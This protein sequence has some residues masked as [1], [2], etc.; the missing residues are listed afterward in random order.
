MGKMKPI[1]KARTGLVAAQITQEY[2]SPIPSANE[3]EGYRMVDPSF[4]DRI[5]KDFEANS[6]TIRELQRKGQQAEIDRDKHG[7]WIFL[8]VSLLTLAV[9]AYAIYAKAEWA[10]AGGAVTAVATMAYKSVVYYTNR[11]FPKSK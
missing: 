10:F 9:I 6:A 3:M 1:D 2:I 11:K 5:M 8:I 4:P 7:Q